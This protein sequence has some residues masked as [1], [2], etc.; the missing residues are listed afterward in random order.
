MIY[1]P[2]VPIGYI[3]IQYPNQALP[4]EIWPSTGWSDVSSQYD[5][6]FFRANGGSSSSFGSVQ[7]ENSPRL[8]NILS[9]IDDGYRAFD[10]N[11]PPGSWSPRITLG[12]WSGDNV[13]SQFLVSGGEVRPRNMAVRIWK[14]IN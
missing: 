2:K 3:Y 12:A 14:R 5:G 10:I 7:D 4:N 13:Q 8:T 11:V 1:Y 6:V 9:R